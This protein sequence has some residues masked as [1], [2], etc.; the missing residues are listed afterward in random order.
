MSERY[1]SLKKW[2]IKS[3]K[4][5]SMRGCISL[6]NLGLR[7]LYCVPRAEISREK[8]IKFAASSGVGA[9]M[10]EVILVKNMP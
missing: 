8:M 6:H 3:S 9:I 1:E 2:E 7:R 5:M 10:V 4:I